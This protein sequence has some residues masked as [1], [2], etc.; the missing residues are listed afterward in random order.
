MIHLNAGNLWTHK[1]LNKVIELNDQHEDTIKVTSL[2]GSISKLTPTARSSD[3]IPYLEWNEIDSFVDKAKKNDIAIRYTLN[4]SCLGSLQDFKAVWDNKLKDDIKEL[5][6]IGIREWTITSALLMEL[7][8]EM[9]PDDF[10]E[11]STIAEVSTA[12]DI[13]RWQV[14]GAK[15]VNISTNINRDFDAIK[16]ITKVG[17]R[18]SIL[19]NEACLYRCPYRRDCYNLSSHNSERS[20]ELF[21]YYPFRYCNNIR[22]N[23]LTEWLKAR[24]LLPQWLRLYQVMLGVDSFKIAFRTHPYERAVPILELYM[25]QIHE[26][27]YLDLWPTIK[28]LGDTVEPKDMQY[29]SCKELDDI[30]FFTNMATLGSK[31]SS[32]ECGVNCTYCDAVIAQVTRNA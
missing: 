5:H 3:R 7:M 14:L 29:I 27:N 9:F 16:A 11:V 10:L 24:M 22:M 31:C 30:G 23:N 32:S 8:A 6:A 19:A 21:N 26:G 15:G 13:K 2:F 4:A 12:E 28:H 25:N 1:Y 18:V 20:E 17:P